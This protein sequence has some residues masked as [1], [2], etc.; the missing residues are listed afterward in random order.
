MRKA[1]VAAL[2]VL[3]AL[4]SGLFAAGAAGA[5]SRLVSSD[6]ADGASMSTSPAAVSLTFNEAV[7]ESFAVLTVVG[8]DGNFWQQGEPTVVGPT[9]KV[10]LR[11]LGPAGDYQVNYRVTSAD[12][13]P[14]EGKRTFTLTVAGTGTPGPAATET[15]SESTGLPVWPFIVAGIVILLGGAGV[16]VWMSR[17]RD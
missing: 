16:V 6:P 12:G 9:V 10:A 7:Q 17:R 8:P 4:L 2:A 13:H 1:I 14:V 11:P 5:H 15:A 3:L